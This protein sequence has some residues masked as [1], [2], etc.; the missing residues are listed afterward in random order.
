MIEDSAVKLWCCRFLGYGLWSTLYG[1][2]AHE[3]DL[4]TVADLG[5]YAHGETPGLGGEVGNPK[6]KGL[7]PGRAA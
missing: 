6:W 4:E 7:W 2:I 3:G 1:F 5:F